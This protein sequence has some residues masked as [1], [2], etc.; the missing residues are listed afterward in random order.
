GLFKELGEA[1]MNYFEDIDLYCCLTNA[2]GK[3]SLEKNFGF[4]TV[5]NIETMCLPNNT[6]MDAKSQ[7][8]M[9]API[10]IN[11]KFNSAEFMIN[12][13]VMFL[14]DDNFRRWRFAMHPFN[15]YC[16]MQMELGEFAVV[17]KYYDKSGDVI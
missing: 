5:D 17:N 16:I 10:T 13:T 8:Y 12:D 11:T 2:I 3:R 9:C 1:A 6:L 7:D 14:A 4:R 15:S